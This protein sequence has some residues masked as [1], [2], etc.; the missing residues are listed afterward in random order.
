MKNLWLKKVVCLVF[1]LLYISMFAEAKNNWIEVKSRNFTVVGNAGEKSIRNVAV[2]LEQFRETLHLLFPKANLDREVPTVVY[3]FGS[4]DSFREFKPRV[5][6]KIQDNVAGY[7]MERSD[8]MYIAISKD[9]RGSLTPYETIFHEY[10]HYVLDNNLDDVPPWFNEGMAEFYSTFDIEKDGKT[11]KIG[12]PISRHFDS[13]QRKSLMPI[14]KLL[15]TSYGENFSENNKSNIFYAQSWAFVHYLTLGN[16]GKRQKQLF[17]F[18]EKLNTGISLEENFKQSFETDF[19]GMDKEL[20]KYTQRLTFPVTNYTINTAIEFENSL[21]SRQISDG[22]VELQLGKLA[23]NLGER[24]AGEAR[25]RKALKLEP[26]LEGANLWVGYV[27]MIGKNYTEAEKLLNRAIELDPKDYLA[28]TYKAYLSG[29]QRNPEQALTEY[30]RAIELQPK[31]ARVQ[32]NLASYQSATGNDDAA[33]V[34]Y[35]NALRLDS[36]NPNYYYS[37]SIVSL[38]IRRGILASVHAQNWLRIK[39]W[40][41]SPSVYAVLIA[42]FGYRISKQTVNADKILQIASEK[43]DKSVWGYS[44]VRYLQKQITADEL[45]KLAAADNDKLTEAHCYIGLDLIF[46]DQKDQ[47]VPHLQWVKDNGN[48]DFIEYGFAVAEL[49]RAS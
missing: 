48:K 11:F 41:K 38:R 5:K 46:N 40:D 47:A 39:G 29:A 12:A 21:A 30:R 44:V 14:E 7:I 28:H 4:D 6:G 49:K 13:F 34:T 19:K 43:L 8:Q 36:R 33:F 42:H 1:A 31:M 23:Y 3:V 24:E 22:E 25:L 37:S 10:Y 32:A 16:E 26:D 17:K 9:T 27:S 45:L 20:Q 15:K 18:L 35:Q 2:R